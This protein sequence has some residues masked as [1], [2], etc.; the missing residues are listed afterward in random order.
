MRVG[1]FYP[2]AATVLGFA[3]HEHRRGQRRGS[4]SS[5]LGEAGV[6]KPAG[7]TEAAEAEPRGRPLSD[8]MFMGATLC[9]AWAIVEY[10]YEF[11][12]LEAEGETT[13]L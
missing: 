13:E 6:V 9:F 1:Y 12:Y 2:V 8:Y 3:R 11:M 4:A 10:I 5:L 7:M